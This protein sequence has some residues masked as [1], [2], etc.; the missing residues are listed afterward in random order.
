MLSSL[1]QGGANR[2]GNAGN[3]SSIFM[4][5]AA[6]TSTALENYL[7]RQTPPRLSHVTERALGQKA[8]APW[9]ST[10]PASN[11]AQLGLWPGSSAFWI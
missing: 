7:T 10:K 6:G 3:T 8:A 11:K 1:P 9:R 2:L 4:A 5:A